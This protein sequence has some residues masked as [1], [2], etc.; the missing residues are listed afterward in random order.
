M[1]SDNCSQMS[2]LNWPIVFCGGLCRCSHVCI[3][4]GLTCRNQVIVV[5]KQ[6]TESIAGG[7]YH[8]RESNFHGARIFYDLPLN[9][10][11]IWR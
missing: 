11:N 9:T 3:F 4:A 5:T 7:Y 2:S 1:N 6:G 10:E 8:P